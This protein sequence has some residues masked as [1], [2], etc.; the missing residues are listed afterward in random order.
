MIQMY[1]NAKFVAGVLCTLATIGW[2]VQG[3]G[4][5]YYY[6]QVMFGS[7]GLLYSDS[8]CLNLDLDPPQCCWSLNGKGKQDHQCLGDYINS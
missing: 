5:A 3:L 6:R 7:L 4:N 8:N 2:L 1:A